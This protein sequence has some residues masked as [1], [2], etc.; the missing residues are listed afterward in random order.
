MLPE[1]EV[2]DPNKPP[3]ADVCPNSPVPV[4]VL[5]FCPKA[6][7]PPNKPPLEALVVVV[8]APKP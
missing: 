8:F 7:V 5:D 2:F 6:D 4:V 1:P 3:D